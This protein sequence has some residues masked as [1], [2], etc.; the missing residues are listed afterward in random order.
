LRRHLTPIGGLGV[1]FFRN[2]KS[3]TPESRSE[4]QQRDRTLAGMR[5][6]GTPIAV[7]YAARPLQM[8]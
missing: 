8:D 4:T 1:S 7:G 5:A 2:F 3:L 6:R